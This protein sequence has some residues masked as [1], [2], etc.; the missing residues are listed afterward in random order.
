MMMSNN[1]YHTSSQQRSIVLWVWLTIT[2]LLNCTL[3][4]PPPHQCLFCPSLSSTILLLFILESFLIFFIIKAELFFLGVH[5]VH[6]AIFLPLARQLIIK[7]VTVSLNHFQRVLF[8]ERRLRD[9]TLA[10][11]CCRLGTATLMVLVDL[12]GI[13]HL[14]VCGVGSSYADLRLVVKTAAS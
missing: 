8:L 9:D 12:R 4:T 14:F 1:K 3:I 10:K 11:L 7:V 6:Y 13:D 5:K 2:T